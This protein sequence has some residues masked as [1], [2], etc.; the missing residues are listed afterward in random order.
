MKTCRRLLT[1]YWGCGMVLLTATAGLA[2]GRQAM[3]K[4]RN[5]LVDQVIVGS[6]ITDPRVIE[7]MRTVPRH[8]FVPL[9]QRKNAYYDMSLPIGESQTIS[10]P[11]IV[12]FMTEQIQPQPGDRVLE[13]GT[14]SGYQAAVLS[15]LVREVYTI[16]IVAPLGHHAEKVLKQLHYDNV[17]VKV[18]DGFQGWPQHAPFDKIIVTC[19]PESIPQALQEQLKE[20]GRMAIPIGE[21]YQQNLMILEKVEGKLVTEGMKP[22]LFVPMTGLAEQRRKVQ[23]DPTRPTLFNGDFEETLEGQEDT[24]AGWYFLRQMTLVTAADAP[25][26]QRYAAFKNAEPGRPALALQGMGV[27]GRQVKQL[28]VTL[29]V[30]AEDVRPGPVPSDVAMLIVIYFDEN[31]AD[32]G[33]GI[34]GPWRGTFGWQVQSARIDVPARA[35]EAIVRIGLFG[36]TGRLWLDNIQV[37]GIQGKGYEG[38]RAEPRQAK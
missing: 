14:G 27:D 2:Q 6:G 10:A 3:E 17:H 38:K 8:E 34:M 32:A 26:G 12:A 16:E 25:S 5:R 11:S 1:A 33:Q 29:H 28:K 13:I 20:G 30:R 37:E 19:S 36:A 15:G 31:R 23:P 24:P 18:G 22:T 9:A 7:V 21:R 35:R 4:E